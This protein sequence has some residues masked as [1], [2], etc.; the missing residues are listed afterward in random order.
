MARSRKSREIP[1]SEVRPGDVFLMPLEDGRFGACRVLQRK[2]DSS[3]VLVAAS[4]WIGTAEP[5]LAEPQLQ[6]T[7]RPTHHACTGAPAMLWV[8]D[9]VPETFRLL[10][11]LP[12]TSEELD[13]EIHV[14]GS[15]GYCSIQVLMQWRW[16]HEREIVLAEEE[17]ERRKQ[18][19]SREAHRRAYKPL[20]ARTLEEFRRHTHF[21]GWNGYVAAVQVRASRRIIRDAIDAL[22]EL[23]PEGPAPAKIDV[24]RLAIERFNALQAEEHFIMTIERE[25]ICGLLN[26]LAGL[27][28]LDDY[29]NA[30]TSARDW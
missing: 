21:A 14:F 20:P 26:D 11:S 23:G 7:L 16:D 22:I 9:P 25:H 10:G 29:S 15:W 8:G 5:D 12:P 2:E 1:L 28:D 17:A 24:F 18:Q 27:V 4:P 13:L 6:T 3:G 19:D 30:L